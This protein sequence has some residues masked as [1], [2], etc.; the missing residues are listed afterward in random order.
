METGKTKPT[1][2]PTQTNTKPQP[3]NPPPPKPTTKNL[4]AEVKEVFLGGW[5]FL[6]GEP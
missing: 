3:T 4:G 1:N 6:V 2:P 5:T